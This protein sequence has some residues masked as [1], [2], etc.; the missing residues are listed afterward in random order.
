MQTKRNKIEEIKYVE[1]QSV[2]E[3]ISYIEWCF[4]TYPFE[5][6]FSYIDPF[7]KNSD[8]K[9]LDL[10]CGNG[11]L[12]F[13]LEKR[14]SKKVYGIDIADGF[15]KVANAYKVKKGYNTQF[16][17]TDAENTGFRS[18][19]FD[20]I[21]ILD[22]LHHFPD[23]TDVLK[24]IYRILKKGGTLI[25][26]EPNPLNPLIVFDRIKRDILEGKWRRDHEKHYGKSEYI[27]SFKK[28]GFDIVENKTIRYIPKFKSKNLLKYDHLFNKIPIINSFGFVTYICGRK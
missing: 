21:L 16:L 10:C 14:T 22:A 12:S 4:E 2:D 20:I 6:Y 25:I 24:E 28:A 8:M 5:T 26:F 13:W 11:F 3:I 19:S 1:N 9:I 7:L 23:S 27:S 17:I 18:N 15:V